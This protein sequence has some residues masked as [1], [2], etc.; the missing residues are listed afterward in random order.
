ME[1]RGTTRR[2]PRLVIDGQVLVE[3]HF[4]GVGQYAAGVLRALDGLLFDEIEVDARLAVPFKRIERLG[5]FG[6]RHL[7]PLPIPTPLSIQRKL[8]VAGRMPPMD[9]VLGPGTY[10]FPN[11][12]RWPL[13]RS[14][15]VTAVH[16]ISF[17]V[18]P[19]FADADNGAFLRREVRNSVTRSDRVTALTATTADEIARHYDADRGRIDVVGCAVDRTRFYRRSAAE[20]ARV[21]RQH[22]IYG[23]YVIAVGNIEPRKNQVRLI[24]AFRALPPDVGGDLTLVLAGAGAWNE[25]EI[26]ERE[27]QAVAAG[28]RVRVLLGSVSDDDLP[29]LYTGARCS[30]YVSLYEGF[31]MPPLESMACGTPV[32]ASTASVMPEVTGGA[33]RLV[34]VDAPEPITA[35]LADVL[36]L[37][38]AARADMVAAGLANVGRYDWTD[39]ARALVRSLGEAGGW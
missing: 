15:S 34:D 30:A 13:L 18:L 8:I 10:F 33:A 5:R 2:R 7:R 22:G 27:R 17:E 36:G 25:G 21:T 38:A 9:L 12:W 16:D 1:R 6:F 3:D 23:D 14:P 32:V 24:E 35:G 31:G 39:S 28:C 11:F 20:V 37:D 19:Q 26:R 4:S 29:A